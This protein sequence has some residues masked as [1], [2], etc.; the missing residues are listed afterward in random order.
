MDIRSN[1]E[2]GQERKWTFLY[3]FLSNV[4][5]TAESILTIAV[6]NA[7]GLVFCCVPGSPKVKMLL[8]EGPVLNIIHFV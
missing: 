8:Y 4:A 3:T 2:T 7:Y 5:S 6:P 1:V